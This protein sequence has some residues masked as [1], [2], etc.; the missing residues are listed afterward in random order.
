MEKLPYSSQYREKAEK[1]QVVDIRRGACKGLYDI[2]FPAKRKGFFIAQQPC[3]TAPQA[4]W[5]DSPSTFAGPHCKKKEE[6]HSTAGTRR[7]DRGLF[8]S[9]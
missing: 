6:A 2:E 3:L 9:V 5:K 4:C 8:C 7:H 1:V